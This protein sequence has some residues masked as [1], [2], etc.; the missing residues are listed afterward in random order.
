MF[1]QML[2]NKF[3]DF[4]PKAQAVGVG[5]ARLSTEK[6]FLP[7][8]KTSRRPLVGAPDGAGGMN[9][10]SKVSIK[11]CL[12]L[13]PQLAI[14]GLIEL[15]IVSNTTNAFGQLPGLLPSS[16]S[17]ASNSIRSMASPFVRQ[18]SLLTS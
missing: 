14:V 6:K 18:L 8:G 17:I 1:L 13:I 9:K 2:L 7:V 3:A 4:H 5:T 11:P 12:S 15:C 10:P 16:K